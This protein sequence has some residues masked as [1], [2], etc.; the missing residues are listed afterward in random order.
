MQKGCIKEIIACTAFLEVTGKRW[1]KAFFSSLETTDPG[2]ER[3]SRLKKKI[4]RSYSSCYRKAYVTR[5]SMSRFQK[6]ARS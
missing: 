4:T 5:R 2:G 3:R 6:I 1:K